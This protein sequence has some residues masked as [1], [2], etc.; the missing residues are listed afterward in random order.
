MNE[1]RE[2]KWVSVVNIYK[3]DE[4]YNADSNAG[5]IY[6][7]KHRNSEGEQQDTRPP[8]PSSC[9]PPLKK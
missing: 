2:R 7:P 6:I 9:A 4:K 5:V 8:F 1:D 3:Q